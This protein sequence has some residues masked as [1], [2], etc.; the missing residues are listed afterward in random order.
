MAPRSAT[1][2]FS[3]LCIFVS[4]GWECYHSDIIATQMGGVSNYIEHYILVKILETF[5]YDSFLSELLEEKIIC[6][7]SRFF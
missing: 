7:Q 2:Y 1:H 6:I 5:Y 3:L 4:T